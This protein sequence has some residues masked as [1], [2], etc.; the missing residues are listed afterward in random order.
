MYRCGICNDF[1]FDQTISCK[2]HMTEQH[3]GFGYRCDDCKTVVSRRAAH[4]NCEGKLQLIN[5]LTMTMTEEDKESFDKF[6]RERDRRIIAERVPFSQK[7]LIQ[8]DSR[9]KSHLKNKENV[10]PK[11]KSILEKLYKP[12]SLKFD[13]KP[14]RKDKKEKKTK[15]D[16][17]KEVK[18]EKP[19]ETVTVEKPE[20]RL[21]N[22]NQEVKEKVSSPDMVDRR[23]QLNTLL[24]DLETSPVKDTEIISIIAN[25]EFSDNESIVEDLA[26]PMEIEKQKVLEVNSSTPAK[27]ISPPE[28]AVPVSPIATHKESKSRENSEDLY[29]PTAATTVDTELSYEPTPTKTLKLEAIWKSQQTRFILNVGGVKFET[30]ASVINNFPNSVLSAM[31]APGSVVTPYSIDGRACYFLDRD[32]KHFPIIMNYL[33]NKARLHSDILPRDLKQLREL[34]IECNFYELSHLESHVQKKILDI[35]HG[36]LF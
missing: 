2:R 8:K 18:K 27:P 31:I 7:V 9:R 29:V 21:Q 13:Q 35:Q 33:R 15:R 12:V 10:S 36:S 32:P 22:V 19:K 16:K 28:I 1:A 24:K 3:S 20:V 26:V 23:Q 30:S 17:P 5:R 14:D 6:Q 25:E 4:R 34:Q 11:K